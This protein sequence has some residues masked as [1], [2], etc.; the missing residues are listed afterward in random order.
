MGD[1]QKIAVIGGRRSGKTALIQRFMHDRFVADYE[2]TIDDVPAWKL[3]TLDHNLRVP[4][5]ILE[6]LPQ[7]DDDDDEHPAVA[8]QYAHSSDGVVLTYSVAS[9][10]SLDDA[11]ALQK[12][13]ARARDAEGGGGQAVPVVLVGCM[14]DL[15]EEGRREVEEAEG[16]AAAKAMR[17][18]WFG[19]AS[20]KTGV[21]VDEVFYA[22]ARCV[23][24]ERVAK[25]VGGGGEGQASSS[26]SRKCV[27]M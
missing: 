7:N 27:V 6:C 2:P 12:E 19:E 13:I 15:G 25:G 24:D 4:T 9:R 1:I 26:S 11:F 22:L 23:R 17:A 21:N 5:D 18:A 16:R 10:A 8:A 14:A 3:I 20:A